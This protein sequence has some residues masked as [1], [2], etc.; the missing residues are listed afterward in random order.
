MRIIDISAGV[1]G[2]ELYPGDPA[3][4]VEALRSMSEGYECNV[5]ALNFCVHTGTHADAP[6]HFLEDGAAIDDIS[7]EAFVGPCR[8][9]E[10][11]PGPI[12][13]ENVNNLFPRDCDRL[14]IKSGGK[15]WFMDSAAQEAAAMGYT[16]IGTDALSVG[17]KGS[18]T[19]PHRALLSSGIAILENLRLD[20][21]EPGAYFLIAPPIK[22]DG[23]E[24]APV[25]ALLIPDIFAWGGRA[26]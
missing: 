2:A 17:T 16:L 10:L 26:R 20:C 25:R 21:V 3:P 7:P 19:E 22:L 4:R 23:L 15:A 13:G 14:L 8:V 24:A 6:L 1:I 18:Q 9:I 5:S 12:T 11:R